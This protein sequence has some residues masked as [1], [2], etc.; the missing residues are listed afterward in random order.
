MRRYYTKVRKI[1]AINKETNERMAFDS[2]NKAAD[3]LGIGE[4]VVRE[5]LHNPFHYSHKDGRPKDR[6]G[7]IL[8]NAKYLPF[9]FEYEYPDTPLLTLW[10]DDSDLMSID[11]YTMTQA[12]RS[13][14][15]NKRVLYALKKK[16]VI[17]EP[18][19]PIMDPITGVWWYVVFHTLE[20]SGA[21]V[22]NFKKQLQP[23]K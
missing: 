11:C 19:D 13:I 4:H 10:P 16:A 9:E 1:I 5:S 14:N 3:A 8:L 15:V 7:R 12:C 21:G 18:T 17:E 6:F 22:C 2:I 23:N 20:G